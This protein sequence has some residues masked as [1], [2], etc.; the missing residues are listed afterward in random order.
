MAIDALSNEQRLTKLSAS[1]GIGNPTIRYLG[2]QNVKKLGTNRRS[3]ILKKIGDTK[4]PFEKRY[5]D[6]LNSL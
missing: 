2:D 6:Y 5:N 4:E 3:E 1:T